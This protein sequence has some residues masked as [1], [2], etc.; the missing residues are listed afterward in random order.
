V[1]YPNLTSATQF[2][3]LLMW[4]KYLPTHFNTQVL[5]FLVKQGRRPMR[6]F[7]QV[8][9]QPPPTTQNVN[10]SGHLFFRAHDGSR[11]MANDGPSIIDRNLEY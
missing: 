6:V 1:N 4:R 8:A 7:H 5:T 10:S 2:L 3:L 9:V 11:H